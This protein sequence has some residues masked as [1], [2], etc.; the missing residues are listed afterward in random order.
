VKEVSVILPTYNER[1]NLPLLIERIGRVFAEGGIAGEVVVVDDHSPDGTGRLA[2]Q[3]RGRYRFLKVVHRPR[4]LGLGSAY[5]EGFRVAEG[6]LL[7][8]MDADLSH[9]PSY[10]PSFMEKARSAEVVVGSRYV[11]GGGLIGWGPYRRLVSRVANFLAG[12]VVGAEVKDITSGYRAYRREVFERVPLGEIRSSGY[13][14]QLEIL[15]E[16]VRGGFRVDS[17][18]IVFTDRRKGESK[19]SLREILGFLGLVFRLGW[20]KLSPRHSR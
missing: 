10:I 9:D 20:R 11:E 2:E 16:I 1:E 3:L 15:H 5:R 7:L 4:K 12:L 18:P 6:K 14:F 8:T 19:L 17:V 13:A